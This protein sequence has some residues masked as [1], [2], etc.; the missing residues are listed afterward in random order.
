M[1]SISFL[2]PSPLYKGAGVLRL[3]D[4]NK[5]DR[6]VG[7]GSQCVTE[8]KKKSSDSSGTTSSHARK[9]SETRAKTRDSNTMSKVKCYNCEEDGHPRSRCP[10]NHRALK[11]GSKPPD[12]K[13]SFCLKELA[14]RRIRK[15]IKKTNKLYM[16]HIQRPTANNNRQ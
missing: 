10:K 15:S 4:R 8:N 12:R 5:E 2:L 3:Q 13:F 9:S 14:I 16:F 1:S 6:L 7:V 11:D